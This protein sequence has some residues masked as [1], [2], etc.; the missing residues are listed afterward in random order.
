M[1]LRFSA[2]QQAYPFEDD[3]EEDLPSEIVAELD[4]REQMR[5]RTKDEE[6]SVFSDA[7]QDAFKKY[8]NEVKKEKKDDQPQIIH[9]RFRYPF[10]SF[11]NTGPMTTRYF[12]WKCLKG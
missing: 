8:Q 2:Y 11:P 9:C 1:V 6:E 3:A 7:V 10:F 12:V 5:S 4:A